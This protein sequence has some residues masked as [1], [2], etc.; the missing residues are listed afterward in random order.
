MRPRQ[1][2]GRSGAAVAPVAAAA[3]RR[4]LGTG[5]AARL[6]AGDHRH[7]QRA[8]AV[9]A[10]LDHLARL[11]VAGLLAASVRRAHR[12]A[13]VDHVAGTERLGGRGVLDDLRERVDHAAGARFLRRPATD[14]ERLVQVG[15]RVAVE[16]LGS[17]PRLLGRERAWPWATNQ[18]RGKGGRRRRRAPPQPTRQRAGALGRGEGAD[19]GSRPHAAGPADQAGPS[20]HVD[21]RLQATRD[22]NLYAAFNVATGEVL[23]RLTQRH[24]GT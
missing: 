3:D 4:Q 21:A 14:A 23:G 24:R 1:R 19:S 20:R 12:R 16:L 5:Q 11:E 13:V 18:S 15:H 22:Q 6:L 17:D 8:D 9:D 10:C 2:A 7:A